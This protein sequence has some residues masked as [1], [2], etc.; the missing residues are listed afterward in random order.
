LSARQFVVIIVPPVPPVHEL[1]HIIVHPVRFNVKFAKF[2]L[3]SNSIDE[4]AVST[5][6]TL[7]KAIYTLLE[8]AN[9]NISVG[10]VSLAV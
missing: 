10:L 5:T 1:E 4:L 8:L 3:K 9:P 2:G 6:D 7:S